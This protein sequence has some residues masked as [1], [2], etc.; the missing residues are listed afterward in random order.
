[1]GRKSSL[2]LLGEESRPETFS[3]RRIWRSEGTAG[4]TMDFHPQSS[5]LYLTRE[6]DPNPS[7]QLPLGR[8]GLVIFFCLCKKKKRSFVMDGE[9]SPFL[10]VVRIKCPVYNSS[11]RD[12]SHVERRTAA[13]HET[14]E[15]DD[16]QENS[17]RFAPAVF[18]TRTC[19][20]FFGGV[21]GI[22]MEPTA[23]TI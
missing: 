4:G 10:S 12:F 18:I 3:E 13:T 23:L 21:A 14:R 6:A 9:S 17:M 7:L 19:L 8:G 20:Y 2:H 16:G 1:M 22:V 15:A 5:P 11:R